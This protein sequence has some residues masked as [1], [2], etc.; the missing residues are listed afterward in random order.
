[1]PPTL[2]V[3]PLSNRIV[4]LFPAPGIEVKLLKEVV[5]EMVAVAVPVKLTVPDPA[6][7]KP[8]LLQLPPTLR[9]VLPD[10][11]VPVLLIET[12]PVTVTALATVLMVP[13]AE[14]LRESTVRGSRRVTVVE[15]VCT[16]TAPRLLRAEVRFWGP[17]PLKVKVPVPLV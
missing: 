6:L 3:F 11:S 2:C 7:N 10:V 12:S 13:F 4:L 16:L 5:P 8:E 9:T 14:M 15:R 1:V 17:P